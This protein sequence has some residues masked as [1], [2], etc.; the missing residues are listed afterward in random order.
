M[1]SSRRGS[2]NTFFG[3][4][5]VFGIIVVIIGFV[6]GCDPKPKNATNVPSS[7]VVRWQAP[8]KQYPPLKAGE[9]VYVWDGKDD[10][11]IVVAGDQMFINDRPWQWVK[12]PHERVDFYV[13]D[14]GVLQKIY[15]DGVALSLE[16]WPGRTVSTLRFA[17]KPFE[18]ES[19]GITLV[20]IRTRR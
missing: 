7:T 6:R 18:R 16:G 11:K 15:A 10:L 9:T 13:T 2:V 5:M 20:T 19:K 14:Y 4:L 3:L 12:L 1:I 8:P 17:F